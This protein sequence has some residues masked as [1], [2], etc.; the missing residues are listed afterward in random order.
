M[1]LVYYT[2]T[3]KF[4][5]IV[6]LFFCTTLLYLFPLTKGLILLPLD[7]LVSR[8]N[9]WYSPATILLKNPYMQ[10]SVVQLYPWRHF[11][12]QSFKN[13]IIP[14]W[15][16]YQFAGQPFMAGMKPMVFYPFNFLFFVGEAWSWNAL[17]F[18]QIFL[19]M[20]FSYA[21]ARELGLGKIFSYLTSFAF[22]L[23]S[24]MI[25]VL[26]FGSEGHVLLWTP[27][28][29]LCAKRYLEEPQGKYLLI[30]GFT[31]A[32]SIFAGHLQYTAYILLALA[33]FILFYGRYVKAKTST[34]VFLFLSLLLGLGLSAPQLLPSLE[35]FS[36]SKRGIE[37]SYELFANG[38]VEPPKVLRLFSSDFFGNPT[39]G[40]L[41]ISYIEQ[42]GYFGLIP[43]FFSLYAMIFLRKNIFVKYFTFVFIISLLLSLR[44]IGQ[45]L[46]LLKIPVITSSSGGRIFFLTLFSGSILSGF[47]FYEF[48]KKELMKR[49]LIFLL[50]FSLFLILIVWGMSLSDV[51]LRNLLFT[52]LGFS[53]FLGGALIYIFLKN[54]NFLARNCL[55][56]FILVLTFF[57]FFRL[58]Y[59]FLTFS[60]PKFLYPETEVVDYLQKLSE[61][62]MA[63]NFGLVEPELATLLN[64]YTLETYNPLYLA[65][66][67]L[68]FQALQG[69]PDGEKLPVNKYFF[70]FKNKGLKYALDFLGVS[71]VV[72]GKDVNPAIE[73]FT[74]GAEKDFVLEYKDEKY[75]IYRNNTALS[76]FGLYYKFQ[77]VENDD[78]ALELIS[79][80]F[81]NFREEIIL[82]EDLPLA[83]QKGQGSVELLSVNPNKQKFLVKTN[84]P[85]LFHISDSY[86]P[87]WRAKVNNQ[88]AHIYRA[89]YNFR[90]VLVPAGESIVEFSYL[91]T[92]F[93]LG[94]IIALFSVIT[95]LSLSKK[96]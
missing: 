69:R 35:L 19:S 48:I 4:L 87:G 58:G 60:N 37:S 7:L 2:M 89:N 21:L 43:F 26:E 73:Y 45:I 96:T 70:S 78:Q 40:D 13:H 75:A 44:G 14:L 24:L 6:I 28:F 61:K 77:K 29:F 11:V 54:K 22:S 81:L 90:A 94:L 82:E 86:F 91:P 56:I 12:F 49:K 72:T 3:G 71:F 31:M 8:Y 68:L 64:L 50:L 27:L 52:P 47:G 10:D 16:P 57:D 53:V 79:R 30:L 9:P 74:D 76:R 92:H 66:T 88:T 95:L 62:T 51:E 59:R 85:A 42:S 80:Q 83:L 5:R 67:G 1:F 84:Q 39:T 15:N 55:A 38:L 33:G 65:R 36:Q 46:Y 93:S 17:L 18:L 23:N 25:G 20:L 34:F 63:R 41:K 32:F